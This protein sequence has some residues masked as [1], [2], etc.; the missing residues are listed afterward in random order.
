MRVPLLTGSL[1]KRLVLLV[2]IPTSLFLIAMLAWIALRGFRQTVE[3]TRA[4]ALNLARVQAAQLDRMLGE[5]ARIPE[6][7]AQMLE[8][9]AL[10]TEAELQG[11]LA[12]V[13]ASYPSIYGSCLAFEPHTFVAAREFYAPYC[14]WKDGHVESTDI[15]TPEYNPF[16]WEWYAKPKTLHHA[17]WTE[18]YFDDGGGNALMT[19]HSVPFHKPGSPRTVENFLGIA[20]ID[21]SLD[22]LIHDL[23]SIRVADTGYAFLVSP[24]GRYLVYPDSAKVMKALIQDDNPQLAAVMM[25]GKEGFDRISEPMKNRDAW[26]AHMPVQNGGFTLALVYPN[27][28]I[29]RDAYRALTDLAIIGVIGLA[30]LFIALIIISRSVTRPITKLAMAARKIAAGDLNLSLN[31]QVNI[32]EVRDLASAFEKMM[33]DLRMRMEELKYTTTIKERMTGELNA[34]R[35]IQMS[36]LPKEW[37]DHTA[38]PRR[39]DVS[40]HAVIQPAR[41]IGGDFYDYR[42]LDDNRLAFLIGDVAGK[43]VP[44]ALF[45]AMTQTL[46]KGFSSPDRTASDIMARVN[47]ALCDEAQ[48][49][50]FVTLLYGVLN[51]QSGALDLCNAGH[52]PP[53]LISSEK[54]VSQLQGA[55]NPALGLKR[56]I[57]YHSANYK[58]NPGEKLLLYTDGVTEAFN[59][60]RELYSIQKLELFLKENSEKTVEEIS[61]GILQDVR[62]YSGDEEASDDLTVLALKM[63]GSNGNALL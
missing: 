59:K 7:H 10:K 60:N 53:F 48:T 9:G 54:N 15:G 5:A 33:R 40:L 2:G 34:A 17:L 55:R 26:I 45:M 3:Q 63:T 58:L 8:S 35:R 27:A 22:Q 56:D 49:G 47:N 44:A 19:T 11:Y 37:S 18:P 62:V 13:V 30:A 20:T 46:F 4:S 16:H 28:E 36:M 32:H 31:E 51:V 24:G 50:M 39:A 42:F 52:P 14:Y 41:E 25:S 57:P 23:Q 61:T 12:K 29:M 6:L 43:G 1:S 21:I 38:W